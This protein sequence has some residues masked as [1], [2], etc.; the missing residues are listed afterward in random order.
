MAK[1]R[2]YFIEPMKSML[3]ALGG[4]PATP[5]FLAMIFAPDIKNLISGMVAG[6]YDPLAVTM[7]HRL[8]WMVGITLL[9]WSTFELSVRIYCL[10]TPSRNKGS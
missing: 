1:A 3:R 6:G 10:F 5:V 4:I 9:S 7:A 2:K 8:T